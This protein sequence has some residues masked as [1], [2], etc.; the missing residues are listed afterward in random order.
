MVKKALFVL[1]K[2]ICS[3][4]FTKGCEGDYDCNDRE[5]CNPVDNFFGGQNCKACPGTTYQDCLDAGYATNMGTQRCRSRCV[6]EQC[7]IIKVF[8][9]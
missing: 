3:L 5:F 7:E 6:V 2:A 8:F 1:Y 4:T 9:T